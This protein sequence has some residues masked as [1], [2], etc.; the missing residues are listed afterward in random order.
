ML[1][2]EGKNPLL[3]RNIFLSAMETEKGARGIQMLAIPLGALSRKPDE[4]VAQGP[5]GR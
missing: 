5:E 3:I 2:A 4:A 1:L